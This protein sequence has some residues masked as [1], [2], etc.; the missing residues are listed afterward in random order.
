MAIRVL[1]VDD[2]T[3]MRNTLSRIMER[4]DRFEVVGKAVNGQEGVSLTKELKPDVVTM[5]IE[6]PV[7]NGI[8]ALEKIMAECPTNVVMVSSLT[9]EGAKATLDCLDRGAVDFIP[10]ALQD[11]ERSIFHISEM[12]LEKLES[13]SKIKVR[14]HR[15]STPTSVQGVTGSVDEMKKA[16][17]TVKS[18]SKAVQTAGKKDRFSNAKL[19]LIGT[20]T[21]GPRALQSVVPNL[22]ASMKQPVV[23]AQH[24][25]SNFTGPMAD[26]LDALSSCKVVEGK[27]GDILENGVVYLAPGGVNTRVVKKDG[28][29]QLKVSADE[30]NESIYHPSVDILA[31]S[32][33]ECFGGDIVAVMLTG[34]G[35]DGA[36]EFENLHKKGAYII[37]QDEM[38]CVV[39][40]M[41]K[42]V[43]ERGI[44]N[45]VIGLE[46]I[47]PTLK[48]LL[49]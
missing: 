4:D 2:S 21:G 47:A 41:P 16:V 11:K 36:M 18:E 39:Y 32:A 20:S 40:G 42:S 23:I 29:V 5:D 1:V 43:A 8:E 48:R 44:S 45:E 22:S 27:D 46:E 38:S 6:M 3:F 25:P 33:G 28:R 9:E 15:P 34:M 35:A 7:M 17:S 19:I 31:A 26:R 13:A 14:H 24:M 37:S 49:S 30:K 12:L 10:K